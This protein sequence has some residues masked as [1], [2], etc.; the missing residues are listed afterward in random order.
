MFGRENTHVKYEGMQAF[1]S[2]TC[3]NVVQT[4]TQRKKMSLSPSLS[5]WCLNKAM[6]T[7][8][9]PSR[10]GTWHLAVHFHGVSVIVAPQ[11]KYFETE[12]Q[13]VSIG[14][15]LPRGVIGDPRGTYKTCVTFLWKRCLQTHLADLWVTQ[16]DLEEFWRLLLVILFHW[17]QASE[18]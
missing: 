10:R 14:D 1:M 16:R 7:L 12:G 17:Q 11:D 18:F 9:V 5:K 4:I 13:I 8:E 15:Q 2:W 3:A 6:H